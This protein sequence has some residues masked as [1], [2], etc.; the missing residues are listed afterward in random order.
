MNKELPAGTKLLP[1]NLHM[2]FLLEL[3]PFV[4]QWKW[5]TRVKNVS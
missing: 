2:I 4:C 1:T 5:K 3:F